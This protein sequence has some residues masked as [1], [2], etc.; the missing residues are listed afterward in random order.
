MPPKASQHAA[1][2]EYAALEAKYRHIKEQRIKQ[3]EG[4]LGEE[5]NKARSCC[6]ASRCCLSANS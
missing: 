5:T 2:E 6:L 4:L 1:Q 3:L